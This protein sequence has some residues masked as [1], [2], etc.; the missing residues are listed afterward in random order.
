[1]NKFC[2]PVTHIFFFL[3]LLAF[4]LAAKAQPTFNPDS[5][6]ESD[7]LFAYVPKGNAIT[8]VTQGIY[9]TTIDHVG[10]VIR[11]DKRWQILEAIHRGVV[12][13]P[14]DSFINRNTT[15]NCPPSII[16]GRVTGD[17][18]I[19]SSIRNAMHDIGRPYD[20][21]FMPDDREIYCSELVQKNYVDHSGHLIFQ[22][23]PMSF[24]DRKGHILH[25][26][27]KYYQKAG[28]SVP[29]GKPGSNPGELTR[30]SRIRII[31]S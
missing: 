10:I 26:W 12:I 22:P 6:R 15:A 28:L 23:I 3:F 18:D 17:V 1:M 2:N 8:K 19:P 20:F 29:E 13:T 5:L 7:L 4:D 21:Y 25:Y 30:S 14:L 16:Q 9:G 27:K 24:H 11:K 31:K